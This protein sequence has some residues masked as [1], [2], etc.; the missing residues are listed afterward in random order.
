MSVVGRLKLGLL[1]LSSMSG[2]FRVVILS[3]CRSLKVESVVG[4]VARASV[5]S[6]FVTVVVVVVVPKI[7]D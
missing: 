6:G 4:R 7:R 5:W 1:R 3:L 2:F